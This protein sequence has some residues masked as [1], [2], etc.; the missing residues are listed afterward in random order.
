MRPS[1]IAADAERE[2]VL[3]LDEEERVVDAPGAAILDEHALER[4]RVPVGHHAQQADD[5]SYAAEGSQFSRL[6]LMCDM[7]S[8]ATAP[9]MMR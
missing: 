5:D 7:N 4:Q 9:S 8:S 1:A 3:M 6:D 2:D